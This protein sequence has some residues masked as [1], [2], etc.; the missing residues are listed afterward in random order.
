MGRLACAFAPFE[1]YEASTH[2]V[3]YAEAVG[4]PRGGV[5]GD[6]VRAGIIRAPPSEPDDDRDAPQSRRV[7]RSTMQSC[8]YS[9]WRPAR[10]RPTTS[11]EA[12]SKARCDI[13]PVPMLSAARSGASRTKNSPRQTLS[14]P[15]F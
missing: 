15:I 6:L 9:R 11:S 7:R 8:N 13:E 4:E 14:V 2:L 12:A 3:A 1:R 5:D 10:N